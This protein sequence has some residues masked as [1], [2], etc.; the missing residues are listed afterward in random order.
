MG[1]TK[2]GQFP[3]HRWS[4]QP[5]NPCS[6]PGILFC[7]ENQISLR[8]SK[9]ALEKSVLVNEEDKRAAIDTI[10]QLLFKRLLELVLAR[11]KR[12]EDSQRTPRFCSGFPRYR[13][14]PPPVCRWRTTRPSHRQPA[15]GRKTGSAGLSSG[16]T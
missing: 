1:V 3:I 11:E 8:V 16:A 2:R 12:P 6:S 14:P 13:Q 15:F 7:R 4:K 10:S 9:L 5:A